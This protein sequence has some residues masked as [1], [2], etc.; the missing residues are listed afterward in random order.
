MYKAFK[1]KDVSKSYAT[2]G[3]MHKAVE[4]AGLNELRYTHTTCP[5]TGRF[6]PLFIG[7][8]AVHVIHFGFC[9]VA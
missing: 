9:V 3:N 4:K 5:D 1:A 6:I 7:V 8:D 2:L